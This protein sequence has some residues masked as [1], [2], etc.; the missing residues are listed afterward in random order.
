M[1]LTRRGGMLRALNSYAFF[2]FFFFFIVAR[3]K[4]EA[5]K[6]DKRKKISSVC[7]LKIAR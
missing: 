6:K 5:L 7:S 3:R 1:S 4:N 2:F